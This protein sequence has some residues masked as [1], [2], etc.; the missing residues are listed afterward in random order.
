MRTAFCAKSMSDS[1]TYYVLCSLLVFLFV[2]TPVQAYGQAEK[3]NLGGEPI[4][5]YD[6][7]LSVR[8]IAQANL[9]GD[10][11]TDVIASEYDNT[12]YG[13]VSKVHGINGATGSFLWTYILQDGAR[14]MAVGDLNGDGI[15]DAIIG[16][17][18]NGS[19]TPDGRVHAID[20]TD[21]SQ[22]WTFYIGSTISTIAIA[23]LNGDSDLDVV[24]GC[25]DD[26]IYAIDG[27]LGSLK[28]S[29]NIGSLWINKVAV[30]DVNGDG[31]DDVAFAHEYL[32]GYSN[33]YGMLDGTDGS[34]L[35]MENVPSVNFDAAIGDIDNDGTPEAVFGVVYNDDHGEIIV[36]DALTNSLEWTYN[37]GALDHSN[38]NIVML[39]TD[40]DDDTD[41]DL[42]V[43]TYL[44]D[45]RIRVFNGDT[46]TPMVVSDSIDGN[47]RDLACADITGDGNKEIIAAT[48]DRVDVVSAIDGKE[49]W[50]Y[51]VAGSINSVDYGD[52]NSDGVMDVIAGGGA[53]FVGTP[54][55]PGKGVW[56][57][58]TVLSP[59][60]W[61]YPF[62]QY[63]NAIAVDELTGDGMMDII[64][65]AS[66][67]D[68]ATAIDGA[69]GKELWNWVGTQNLYAVTTGDFDFDGQVDVAVAGND[70][71]VTALNGS[72]GS[73]MW[74]FTTPGDQIYRKCLKAAD[75]NGDGSVDVIVGSDDN[76]VYGIDGNTGTAL[77]STDVGANVGEITL[78]QVSGG[79]PIEVVVGTESSAGTNVFVLDGSDGKVNWNYTAPSGVQH[80]E[81]V[82]VTGDNVTDVFGAIT[83]SGTQQVFLVDGYTQTQIWSTP[84]PVASN[85]N[86]MANGDLNGD[87][88]PDV[89][90][91]G[92]SSDQNVYALNGM[93][94]SILWAF[95]TGGEVNCL[96]V[97][98]MNNDGQNDVIAG[99][100]DNIVYIING[101]TGVDYWQYSTVGDVMDAAIG[102][103]SGNGAPNIAVLT[104]GS[105]GVAY[106]FAS[107][108]DPPVGCCV[109]IRGNVDGDIL[110][111]I[112]IADLVYFV[113][114]S[115]GTPPGPAPPCFEEADVDGSLELN[116]AD[117]VYMV[118]YMFGTPGGPAPLDCP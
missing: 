28:W 27:K 8:T 108:Y 117:I 10:G 93:N 39:I 33:Y 3:L 114:F 73:V 70:D 51:A 58:Q 63:G 71:M 116:I 23:D 98:D 31:F 96:Q 104:F 90:V 17:S 87:D 68:Q 79:S 48:S 112:N 1:F 11:V 105:D 14:S 62:G 56:T 57:L 103:I 76:F 6:S 83:P 115:F 66:L 60:L 25:F 55:N 74:Q 16:A 85:V 92:S 111:E 49:I 101:A 102:D 12:Y 9:N 72:D 43:G 44:G 18:Y 75:V 91:P 41:L 69:T 35:W 82:D 22:L 106:A 89:V 37:L 84:L 2:F 45:H 78:N 99:A 5:I 19:G 113:D 36:V 24:C 7:D 65:V 15:D 34:E 30:G 38:G 13:E 77:W 46:N 61:E 26:Y 50:Y 47:V 4:W 67:D 94:G 53:E 52:F 109:G 100:D 95:H 21:G 110:E 40:T 118:D 80:V 64:T 32:A 20:G 88:I 54:P 107:L 59:L 97:A 86:G 29:K 81:G 42:I